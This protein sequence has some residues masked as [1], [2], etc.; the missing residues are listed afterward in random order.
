[1]TSF[2][3]GQKVVCIADDWHY[4]ISHEADHE[5][6]RVGDICTICGLDDEQIGEVTLWLELAEWSHTG[7]VFEAACFRP[8]VAAEPSIEA[9]EALLQNLLTAAPEEV[10]V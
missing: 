6:P 2:R 8:L 3:I 10:L 4:A 9:L 1:M 5:G 7:L